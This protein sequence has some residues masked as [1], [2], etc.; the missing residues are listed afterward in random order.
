MKPS[1]G[2]KFVAGF[3]SRHAYTVFFIA[4]TALAVVA[5]VAPLPHVSRDAELFLLPWYEKTVE[6]GGFRA[7]ATQIGDFTPAYRLVLALASYIP[8]DPLIKLKLFSITFD[9]VLAAGISALV[10]TCAGSR[11]RA[12]VAYAAALLLPT[13]VMNSS[14]WG[15]CDCVYTS[16]AVW[17]LVLLRRD[18]P[19]AAFWCYG[20]AFA[21]KLQAVFFLPVFVILYFAEKRFS[22]LHFLQVP[23]AFLVSA[24]PAIIA[25]QPF[26]E[27][28]GVYAKQAGEY[29]YM[30]MNYPNLYS[31]TGGEYE[32][33]GGFAVALTLAV[34][35]FTLLFY[36]RRGGGRL[37]PARYLELAVWCALTCVMLLPSMHDRYGYP[38]EM[39][40]VALAVTEPRYWWLAAGAELSGIFAYSHYLFGS[41]SV[42][43]GVAGVAAIAV[44]AVFAVKLFAKR[45]EELYED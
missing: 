32:T 28:L 42:P 16:L 45:K 9:F 15:Q 29:P 12:A 3:V 6:L 5:R 4:A 27:A 20:A 38:A 35:A 37:K 8:G 39:L 17:S 21:F 13:A 26:L 19:F 1:R 18:R 22:L 30:V 36:I 43:S 14:L 40:S 2:E 7:L 34:L 44:Y 41:D 25:G 24:L 23:G 31:V 11:H 33:L 10:Y